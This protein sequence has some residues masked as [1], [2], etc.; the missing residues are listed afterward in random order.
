[1]V[2]EKPV[3]DLLHLLLVPFVRSAQSKYLLTSKQSTDRDIKTIVDRFN[4]MGLKFLTL[5]LPEMADALLEG[6]ESGC[7]PTLQFFQTVKGTKLPKLFGDYWGILFNQD[8][9]RK[10]PR[11]EVEL[12]HEVEAFRFLY[13]IGSFFSKMV[14][15]YPEE[16]VAPFIQKFVETDEGLGYEYTPYILELLSRAS[17]I[18]GQVLEHAD[19]DDIEPKHGPGAVFGGQKQE[20]KWSWTTLFLDLHA[21]YG[22]EYFYASPRHFLDELNDFA[23]LQWKMES[24]T[25]FTLVPKTA[26]KPRGICVEPAEKQ[27]IQQ[28]QFRELVRA[29]ESHPLTRGQVNFESQ[30]IN[31]ELALHSSDGILDFA[32]IDLS[33]ASDR[34]S[35]QLVKDLLRN[36]ANL[37][38]KLNASRS[39]LCQLPDGRTIRL[40]KF[41]PMGSANC[42]PMEAITFFSVCVAAISMVDSEVDYHVH[43]KSVY[44]YG[45]DIILPTRHVQT[46]MDALSAVNFKVNTGK[47]YWRS[48]FRESC[49]L[50][51][52]HGRDVTPIRIKKFLPVN[53]HDGRSLATWC[54]YANAFASLGQVRVAENIFSRL[55]TVLRMKIPYATS[56]AGILSRN[57]DS[58]HAA[59]WLNRA[60]RLCKLRWNDAFQRWEGFVPYSS[61]RYREVRYDS[62]WDQL[63]SDIL[64][65][66]PELDPSKTVVLDS[67]K[68]R[69]GWRPFR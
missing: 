23:S 24:T 9:S 50:H 60:E 47:S 6:V 16:V 45:D 61:V 29:I 11:T 5:H 33:D 67:V 59:L 32:T 69:R 13:Q 14:L 62:G 2:P 57:I 37:W 63:L 7:L 25:R 10:A 56:D 35:S 17:N 28:G 48:S 27:F 31:R 44:V 65:P 52:F 42:F 43:A 18:A 3:V 1:M 15:P 66:N 36:H 55:E 51:A 46:V 53:E 34:V 49:G 21:E 30:Q 12:N 41:A 20:Q 8:G 58:E 39:A 40:K 54:A 38:L 68:I 26:K 64:N 4:V 19:M 22:S